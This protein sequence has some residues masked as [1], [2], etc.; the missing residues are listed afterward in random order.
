M[1]KNRRSS[2]LKKKPKDNEPSTKN[3]S[4]SSKGKDGDSFPS[5]KL[6]LTR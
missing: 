1:T 5:I 3:Q 2:R 4:E 6:V